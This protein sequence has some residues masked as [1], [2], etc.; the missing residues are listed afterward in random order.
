ML[1]VRYEIR[2]SDDAAIVFANYLLT[3]RREV[4][5]TITKSLDSLIWTWGGSADGDRFWL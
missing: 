3:L 5:D 1:L 2:V 4:R